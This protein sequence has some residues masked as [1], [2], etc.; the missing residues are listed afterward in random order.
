MKLITIILR[1]VGIIILSFA[2][3][4][5]INDL[6]ATLKSDMKHNERIIIIVFRVIYIIWFAISIIL[7]IFMKL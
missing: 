1:I 7:F 5:N 4:D 3:K 2:I 6:R